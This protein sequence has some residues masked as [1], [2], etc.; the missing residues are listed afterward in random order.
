MKRNAYDQI[1]CFRRFFNSA[2]RWQK[3]YKCT[4]VSNQYRRTEAEKH[5]KWK[6]H[7][8]LIESITALTFLLFKVWTIL[9]FFKQLSASFYAFIF[10]SDNIYYLLKNNVQLTFCSSLSVSVGCV[11]DII[12]WDVPGILLHYR[13]IPRDWSPKITHKILLAV[14]QSP[15]F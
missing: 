14:K 8:V 3:L 7:A 13:D 15:E 11:V 5:F 2:M 4:V 10:L 6:T 12:T 1:A 9:V